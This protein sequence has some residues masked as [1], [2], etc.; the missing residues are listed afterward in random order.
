MLQLASNLHHMRSN[1]LLTLMFLYSAY[2]QFL[3]DPDHYDRRSDKFKAR[4]KDRLKLRREFPVRLTTPPTHVLLQLLLLMYYYSLLLLMYYSCIVQCVKQPPGSLLCGFYVCEYLRACKKFA[5]SWRQLKKGQD[6]W[7]REQVNQHNFNQTV[8][9]ICKV[10]TD[11]IVHEG[12]EFFNEDSPLG[13]LPEYEPL[14]KW[15]TMLRCPD[16]VYPD[17]FGLGKISNK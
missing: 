13:G 17:I 2:K 1:L 14:R 7:E 3:K 11:K 8:A 12:K 9:D 6:W 4:H 10:V 15:S 5:D 16:Y